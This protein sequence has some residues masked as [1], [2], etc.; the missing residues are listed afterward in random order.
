MLIGELSSRTGAS[1][2]ALRLY[3]TRGLIRAVRAENG[4]R[5]F[6]EGSDEVVAM[7]REAQALGFSLGEIG[8]LL[9]GAAET[10]ISAE[11]LAATLRAKADEIERRIAGLTSLR[12]RLVQRAAAACPIRRAMARKSAR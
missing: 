6:P 9:P 12:E 4:Y 1:R 3:E 2:D 11:D 8:A 10:G 7:I 5:V